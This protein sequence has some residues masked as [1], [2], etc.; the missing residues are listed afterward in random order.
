MTSD[1][2]PASRPDARFWW[3]AAVAV[4][5]RPRLWF[6]ALRQVFRLAQAGWW[7]RSPFLPLPDEHYLEFRLV[8][9]AGT[10]GYPR[11]EE[12]IRYLEWCRD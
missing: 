4:L 5:V 2:P 11:V 8:T 1:P 6:T 9:N 7:R 10:G 12:F 3:R